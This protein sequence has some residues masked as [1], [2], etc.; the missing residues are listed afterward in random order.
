MACG[1]TLL[2][3]IKKTRDRDDRDQ[4]APKVSADKAAVRENVVC[5]GGRRRVLPRARVAQQRM[6]EA[7]TLR[8][9]HTIH[10]GA[11]QVRV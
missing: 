10:L 5:K 7:H 8:P 9:V 1:N 11:T 4:E 2:N 3:A 6:V